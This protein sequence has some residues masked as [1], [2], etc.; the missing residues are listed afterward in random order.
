[1]SD[2]EGFECPRTDNP[3]G[4]RHYRCGGHRRE[5]HGGG[6][7]NGQ[8]LAGT[9]SN[10]RCRHHAGVRPADIIAAHRAEQQAVAI[11]HQ[12]QAAAQEYGLPDLIDPLTALHQLAGEVWA[13]K[14]ACRVLVGQL[15]EL[16]YRAG[17]GEQLRAE[18]AL[19]E[20]SLERAGKVLADLVRLGIED[21]LARLS[22][23]QVASVG[24]AIENTLRELA[25]VLGFDA[26]HPAIRPA[27]ARNLREVER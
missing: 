12:Q 5:K 24:R 19:Y 6:P 2:Q 20:R 22:A 16:R 1:M 7:C 9:R 17:S 8:P 10:P 27:I 13:W 18:I 21:R 3:C 14:E 15:A 4:Q 11:L 26:E 23:R 25:P